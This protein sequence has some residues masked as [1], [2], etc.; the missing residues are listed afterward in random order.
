MLLAC[1]H[2][3]SKRCTAPE[4]SLGDVES[5]DFIWKEKPP[6]N[7]GRGRE[8]EHLIR[9]TASAVGYH[10]IERQR[11]SPYPKSE[12]QSRPLPSVY[13]KRFWKKKYGKEEAKKRIYATTDKAKGALKN[14]QQKR[15]RDICSTV[16]GRFS[17]LTAVGLLRSQ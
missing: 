10:L 5:V 8:N 15:I 3:K 16:G 12:Q 4:V 11:L 6:L 17:V 9:E 7:L 1:T 2:Q 13:L 14:L